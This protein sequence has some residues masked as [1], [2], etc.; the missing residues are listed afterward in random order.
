MTPLSRTPGQAL[1]VSTRISGAFVDP[2][3]APTVTAVLVNGQARILAVD[4]VRITD[5]NIFSPQALPGQYA[6]VFD[7]SS[8][9]LGDIVTILFRAGATGRQIDCSVSGRVCANAGY[10]VPGLI[11]GPPV[12]LPPGGDGAIFDDASVVA[13]VGNSFTQQFAIPDVVAH[14]VNTVL[15]G[16][17]VLGPPPH[18]GSTISSGNDGYYPAQ[19][20]GGMVLYP[21]I[22]QRAP[23]NTGSNDAIDAM[24]SQPLGTYGFAVL[25]SGF[26]QEETGVGGIE[27]ET[28]PGSGA[29]TVVLEVKRRAITEIATRLGGQTQVLVRMTHE[30]YRTNN[31]ADLTQVEAFI[32]RQVL[33]A[34]QLEAEGLAVVI[35]THYV[36]SRLQYGAFGPVGTALTDPVPAYAGLTHSTSAQAGG[37]NWG[38]LNRTQGTVAPFTWNTH[39]NA[40]AAIVEAWLEGY[41]LWGID[42]RGDTTFTSPVGL[43]SPLNNFISPDGLSIYGGHATGIG[44]YPFDPAYN[45]GGPPDSELVFDWSVPTQLQMQTLI[46]DAADDYVAGTT[47]FEPA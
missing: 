27:P 9:R 1:R 38:W 3:I 29:D 6:F 46:V 26:I 8:L 10:G 19:T 40:L 11:P 39:Q 37:R 23:G 17:V 24:A 45:P 16:A 2:A 44:N 31:D 34:R 22:D 18:L 28:V 35:P 13:Y 41:L 25:T 43:P 33:G 36:W 12:I 20:L 32:R 47:E 30:G 15:P 7:G 14:Y 42:P 21:T 4:R 5:G